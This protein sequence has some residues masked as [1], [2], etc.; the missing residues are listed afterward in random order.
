MG[1]EAQFGSVPIMQGGHGSPE[2]LELDAEL[3]E[4]DDPAD[5]PAPPMFPPLELEEPVKMVPPVP[6]PPP[7]EE[8][9]DVTSPLELL[10]LEGGTRTVPLSSRPHAATSEVP[11]ASAR[12]R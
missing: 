8:D 12:Q 2:L 4:D 9:D 3:L 11:N 1:L 5:P 10:A 7:E 6:S